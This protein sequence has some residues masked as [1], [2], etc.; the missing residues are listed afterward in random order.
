MY[1]K[2]KPAEVRTIHIHN[3]TQGQMTMLGIQLQREFQ[4]FLV[5]LQLVLFFSD[6]TI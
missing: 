4:F 3:V 5:Q 1:D 6:E 2:A